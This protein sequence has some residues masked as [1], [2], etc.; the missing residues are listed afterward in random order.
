MML[1][2][3]VFLFLPRL[4]PLLIALAIG[5]AISSC[6][7]SEPPQTEYVLGT[8]CTVNLFE[9]GTRDVYREIF[10]RLR[11]IEDR[12]SANRDGTDVDAVNRAAGDHPVKVHPDVLAV[13][14]DALKFAALSGGALDPTIGPL[15]KLWNIGTDDAR[16]PAPEEI[17]A[18]LPLVDY[19][20]VVVDEAAGTVFLAR[21]GMRLD[22]GAMAKGYAADEVARII[23]ARGIS[24]AIVD[25]GGNIMAVGERQDGQSWRIGVQDPSSERGEHI[26][27]VAVRN[28]T[29]VTS[30]VYERF[31][32]APD[33]VRYHH[34]LSSE[35]GYPVKNGLLSVTI[36]AD[37]SMDADCLSTA[38]FAL[39]P[40]KGRKLVESLPG[41]EAIFIF[42]DFSVE[43][44]HGLSGA[45]R[46]TD[47]R[48]R[49][50]P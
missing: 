42:D 8:V 3:P 40:E 32:I 45:F 21:A 37:K 30:G 29:L 41:V 22:L 9:K 46:M 36:V 23:A 18:A 20:D 35:D 13:L 12:M 19:R 17:A 5:P 16:V 25:L 33:G 28:K 31:F 26:G 39:G 4:S 27:I 1:K 6:A 50:K 10:Q 38:V 43:A 15:V 11:E 2:S 49:M 14:G 7:R 34:I 48:F 24:R 47:T 44:T